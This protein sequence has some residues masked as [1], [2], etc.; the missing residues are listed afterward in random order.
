M[1]QIRLLSLIL[2]V[3]H[4][5]SAQTK[6]TT[7]S[8]QIWVGYF[9]QTRLSNKFGFWADFHIRTKEDFVEELSQGV[10]RLGLTWY[11]KD[12]LRF[13]AGYA[14]FNHYPNDNHKNISQ[15]EH[16]PW[17]QLQWQ[18]S[19]PKLR[20]AHRLRFEQR[21]RRKIL[22]DDQLASG[23]DFNFRLRYNLLARFPLN[24][25]AFQA[26]T[27]SFVA[28][29]EV[30]VNFGKQIVYNY[31]D[32]NRMFLGLAYH[33]NKRDDLQLGY[34]NVFQQ[35]AS[36]NRYRSLHTARLFYFHNLDLRKKSE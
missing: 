23:Y 30:M 29:D 7:S 11:I 25:N 3:A 18:T 10:M 32:Q 35:L 27:F 17:Q 33:L 1:R 12:E 28:S 31:F 16:R 19:Y 5:L 22:S 2:I 13:T 9:N 24:S 4:P 6:G 14:Y 20:L 21:Y 15:P 8:N 36:G 26:N 34:M